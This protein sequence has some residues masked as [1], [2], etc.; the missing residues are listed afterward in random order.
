MLFYL[1]NILYCILKIF[2]FI[3]GCRHGWPN[4]VKI[5]IVHLCMS[6]YLV[7]FYYCNIIRLLYYC[8][9]RFP[10]RIRKVVRNIIINILDHEWKK[11]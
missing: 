4:H 11:L 8:N 10:S 5:N 2:S 9:I 1:Y 3:H 7:S 6:Y